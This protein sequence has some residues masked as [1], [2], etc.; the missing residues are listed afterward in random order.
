[1]AIKIP[2]SPIEY[3][4]G[5]QSQP[6]VASVDPLVYDRGNLFLDFSSK[7]TFNK[8]VAYLPEDACGNKY[9]V[10]GGISTSSNQLNDC[11][12]TPMFSGSLNVTVAA[13]VTEAEFEALVNQLR[14]ELWAKIEEV[15]AGSTIPQTFPF[16]FHIQFLFELFS[17]TRLPVEYGYD[18]FS[19]DSVRAT[20]HDFLLIYYASLFK[21]STRRIPN[22]AGTLVSMPAIPGVKPEI[23]SQF[24]VQSV[25]DNSGTN[26]NFDVLVPAD[27]RV[28]AQSMILNRPDALIAAT[29]S[30]AGTSST[31]PYLSSVPRSGYM[32]E[33]TQ[34]T[35]LEKALVELAFNPYVNTGVQG[36]Q[37]IGNQQF[38]RLSGNFTFQRPTLGGGGSFSFQYNDNTIFFS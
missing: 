36:V 8:P 25:T 19:Q 29:D 35:T 32:T 14:T 1:M 18:S 24:T 6:I 21:A 27:Y 16:L 15:A 7:S 30:L 5:F 3:P 28:L 12:V 20:F 33:N 11:I 26:I 34:V 31:F 17:M 9:Y 2:Q 23:T 22:E 10:K 4:A 38:L 13:N 37:S